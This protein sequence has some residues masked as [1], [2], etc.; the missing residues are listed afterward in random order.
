MVR[1]TYLPG[2]VRCTSGNRY[3]NPS[4]HSDSLFADT[5]FL[6]CFADVRVNEYIIGTGPSVL[7]VIVVS[8]W[9]SR[10]GKSDYEPA[11]IETLRTTWERALTEGGEQRY[12]PFVVTGPDGGITGRE[13]I[14]FL[15]PSSNAF[16]ETW[17]VRA[18]WDVQK[19]EGDTVIAVH[20]DLYGYVF[21][22]DYE[23]IRSQL[24]M[25]LPAFRQAA[26]A[27]H[28]ARVAANGGRIGADSSLPMLVTDTNKL[29]SYF[30][31]IGAY[32]DPDNPPAQPP[33]PYGLFEYLTEEIP[34]C[35]PA[36]G[37]VV[38]P[39]EP[40]TDVFGIPD[41]PGRVFWLGDEP[42]RDIQYFHER[43]SPAHHER[44]FPHPPRK[45][46]PLSQRGEG[47]GHG[48]SQGMPLHRTRLRAEARAFA[49]WFDR[50]TMS[51]HPRLTMSGDSLTRR[52]SAS[53]SPKGRGGGSAGEALAASLT[54]R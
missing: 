35:T 43:T 1:G 34:P 48:R 45:R 53:P 2:T 12:K 14:L 37:S 30:R 15:S 8:N 25:G 32:D 11:E 20:P 54:A 29:E 41:P 42:P 17:M 46:V 47:S 9:H 6:Y 7:T 27:A 44:G 3:L 38:D 22:N 52:A 40:L 36:P 26:T 39:C 19:R 33:P 49:G 21:R 51:G 50:L 31:E 28:E 5:L 18:T 10:N 4:W 24:E 13:A 23:S 16:I